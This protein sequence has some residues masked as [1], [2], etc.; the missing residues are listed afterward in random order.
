M[1]PL[2][3]L[4]TLAAAAV[5][6]AGCGDALSSGDPLTEA[7]AEELAAAMIEQGTADF[8]NAFHRTNPDL[9]PG[10][11]LAPQVEITQTINQT[12]SC[13]GSGTVALAGKFTANS[14]DGSA[15]TISFDYTVTP[16]SCRFTTE[17]EK[18]YTVS[19]DPNLKVSGGFD[20]T[21]TSIKGALNYDGRFAW[22]SAEGMAGSCK[23]D[24]SAEYTFSEG[25]GD[26]SFNGS[27][28][29]SGS[30]CGHTVN[31]TETIQV[32]G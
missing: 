25:T 28:V 7:D 21:Q 18:Q 2:R 15:G 13:E 32:S 5:I 23:F 11:S 30:V 14:E 24:I 6:A 8:G 10:L 20:W 1:K 29:V 9:P 4:L 27:V 12:N 16:A 22:E 31:R 19:G 3:N 26:T 17:S